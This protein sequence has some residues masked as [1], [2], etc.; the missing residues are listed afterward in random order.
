MK[1]KPTQ[2]P[3][4]IAAICLLT[5]VPLLMGGC[6]EFQDAVVS[7]YES[8]TRGI[9]DAAVTLYFDQFRSN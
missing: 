7:A 4:R 1:L 6:P 3:G 8:A 9:V 5:V 2:R